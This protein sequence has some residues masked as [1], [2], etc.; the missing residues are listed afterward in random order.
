GQDSQ[1]ALVDGGSIPDRPAPAPG[2]KP[3][4]Q[5]LHHQ[6]WKPTGDAGSPAQDES[7]GLLV[8]QAD[9][10]KNCT[11]MRSPRGCPAFRVPWE[12]SRFSFPYNGIQ[13]MIGG[14]DRR[15]RR[16]MVSLTS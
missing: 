6:N 15:R 7:C 14:Y 5:A 8:R 3:W 9:E 4:S 13:E 2:E 10:N 16:G 1:P 11:R 12:A